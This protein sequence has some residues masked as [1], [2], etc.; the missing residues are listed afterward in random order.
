MSSVWQ[1]RYMLDIFLMWLETAI[2]AGYT[3]SFSFDQHITSV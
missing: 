3:L 1:P 2:Y